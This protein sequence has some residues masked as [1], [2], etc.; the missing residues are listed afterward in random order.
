ML[1]ATLRSFSSKRSPSLVYISSK[2]SSSTL[3]IMCLVASTVGLS[4]I[5]TRRRSLE[6]G[7]TLECTRPARWTILRFGYAA[8]TVPH[9]SS[10]RLTFWKV[11]LQVRAA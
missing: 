6:I 5:G 8:K 4:C 2:G 11:L 10:L 9:V 7:S 1:V 3:I